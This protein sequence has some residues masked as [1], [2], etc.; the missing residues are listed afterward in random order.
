MNISNSKTF[1]RAFSV[2]VVFL[3]IVCLVISAPPTHGWS[4]VEQA[5]ECQSGI[6]GRILS[7][8][9][10]L[11]V[12]I[13][14]ANA[15]FTMDLNLISPGPQRFLATNRDAGSIVKLGSFPAGV[16]LIFGIFVRDTQ[17]TYVMGSG[18]GNPDGLPHAEVT[19]FPGKRSN[20]GFEDQLGGGD[21]DYNDLLCQVR[22]P[23]SC[24]YAVAPPSQSFGSGGGT[25]SVNVSADSCSW[26]ATSNVSW[27]TI[28]SG[29]SG[30]DNGTVNYSVALNT[31]TD[32]RTGTITL[33][34]LTFT[35][36]QDGRSSQP[37]I[38]GTIRTGKKLFVYGLN[39]DDASV[40]LLNGE[41]QK[42][43][44]DENNP[45]TVLIGKKVGKWARPGDKLRV[46]SSSGML[47][48]EYTYAP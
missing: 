19:C 36:Y 1:T 4:Q 2:S 32:S 27:I 25:G 39:F 46:R 29:G 28:T 9:G 17:K 18:S 48:A 8:G 40:I 44:H 34:G 35:V 41:R 14:P 11:E 24:S 45:Q 37:L 3:S 10:E 7:T 12:E 23:S 20:I 6:G 30:S 15:G 16:E 47:S 42:T 33:Q 26:T 31:S 38:T 22:Q 43:L 21:Q 5:V 13:L